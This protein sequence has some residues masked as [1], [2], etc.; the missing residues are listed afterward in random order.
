MN[1]TS[2]LQGFA[3]ISLVALGCAILSDHWLLMLGIAAVIT[4][5]VKLIR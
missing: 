3:W 5:L 4:V 1:P 2:Y